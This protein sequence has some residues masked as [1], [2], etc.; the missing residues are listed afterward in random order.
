LLGVRYWRGLPVLPANLLSAPAT[1]LLEEAPPLLPRYVPDSSAAAPEAKA[2]EAPAPWRTGDEKRDPNRDLQVIINSSR[3]VASV[4]DLMEENTALTSEERENL[5]KSRKEMDELNKTMGQIG[6]S[7]ISRLTGSLHEMLLVCEVTVSYSGRDE[8][9]THPTM[10]D[11]F[12]LVSSNREAFPYLKSS[13]LLFSL[14]H[15]KFPEGRLLSGG[16]ANGT[17]V[18]PVKRGTQPEEILYKLN[19]S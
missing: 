12:T 10:A 9:M 11:F 16:R 19:Q 4:Y 6:L 2:A 8:F 7:R 3:Y 15:I 5:R 17:M 14:K 1:T 18:F 13:W